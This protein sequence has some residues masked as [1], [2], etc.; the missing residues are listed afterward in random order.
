[1]CQKLA[2]LNI[3]YTAVL[4]EVGSFSLNG[5]QLFRVDTVATFSFKNNETPCNEITQKLMLN[6]TL[7]LY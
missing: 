2:L 3:F 5:M 4:N 1:M 6:T 7:C